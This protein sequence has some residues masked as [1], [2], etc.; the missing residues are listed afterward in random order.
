MEV[1]TFSKKQLFVCADDSHKFENGSTVS[2][3]F[4]DG[5]E[6]TDRRL[7]SDE[8]SFWEDAEIVFKGDVDE[9]KITEEEVDQ[10]ELYCELRDEKKSQATY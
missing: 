10:Y 4:Y 8:P 6:F 3:L 9:S 7:E 5:K 2:R 1:L